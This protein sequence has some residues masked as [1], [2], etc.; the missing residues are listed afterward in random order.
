MKTALGLLGALAA[1]LAVSGALVAS[2]PL[3]ASLS[4]LAFHSLLVDESPPAALAPGTTTTYTMHFRNV[5]TT[6]WQRGGRTQVNLGV[7][8]DATSFA[9]AGLAA[10]WLS[11]TRIVST[12]E[13]LV[14]P[15][16]VGTFTF[17]VRA[18][19]TPGSYRI[20]VRLVA[21][22]ISWLDD[23][24]ASVVVTSDLGFHGQLVDQSAYPVLHPFGT[25]AP[26]SVRIRNVGARAWIKGAPGQQLNLGIVGDDKSLAGLGVEWPSADRVAIQTEPRVGPGGIATF[27]FRIRAGG[28]TGTYPIRLR[29][30]VDGVTWLEDFGLM[31][32]LSVVPAGTATTPAI[33]A[34]ALA[35]TASP[36]SFTA[37]ARANPNSLP[38]GTS[39]TVNATVT[40]STTNTGV[41]VG[42]GIYAPGAATLA[43][44]KWFHNENFA[45][46]EQHQYTVVWPV[47]AGSVAG[48]DTVSVSV[49]SAG[50]KQALA[51][52]F[53]LASFT[54]TTTTAL[55]P[56]TAAPTASA[57]S[58][59]S[60]PSPT[61]APTAAPSPTPAATP[62]PTPVPS[63]ASSAAVSPATAPAGSAVAVTDKVTSASAAT[64]LVDI[65]IWAAGAAAPAYQVWF[66]NLTFAAGQQQTFSASWDVPASAVPGTYTVKLG[67][68]APAWAAQY[69][70]NDAAATFA[71][72]AAPSPT[73][74]PSA[75]PSPP[76]SPS[77]TPSPTP[78]PTSLNDT[79][80]VYSG[81]WAV[82]TAAA[83]YLGD[84]HYSSTAGSSYTVSFRGT[85]V[86][87][88]AAVAP[89]HGIAAIS[90]DGSSPLNV[91][92]YSPTRVDQTLV[93]TSTVLASGTHTLTVTV[94]GR[95]NA[96]STDVILNADRADIVGGGLGP[97][98]TPAPT[99]TPAPTPTPTPAPTPTSAPTPTPTPASTP[100]P[101]PTAAPTATPA[102]SFSTSAS[103]TPTTVSPGG[104]VT[105][106]TSVTSA[107]AATVIVEVY[108][109]APDGTTLLNEQWFDNQTFAAG[110]RRTYTTSW[111]VPAGSAAG[112]Y[113]IDLGVF[114]LGWSTRYSWTDGAATFTVTAPATPAPTPSATPAP[115]P[116]AT[117]APTAAPGT[118]SALHVQGNKIVNALSQNVVLH[119]V[120]RSGFEQGCASYNTLFGE[121]PLDQASVD[122]IKSWRTNVVRVTLN[123][124][125]WLG[126]NGV[127]PAY[128]GSIYQAAVKS[129]VT[130]LNQSGLYA[131]VDLHWSAPGTT[132]ATGQQPMADMDHSPTYWTQVATAFKNN[133]GVIFD[134]YNE[135]WP[136]SNRDTVAAWTCWR[137]GGSCPG[138]PFQAAGM[139]TL[140]NAVRNTGATN[141]ILLGGVQYS[142]T[143]TQ[144]VQYKPADPQNNLAASWHGYEFNWC[145]T[146]TCY[147]SNLGTLAA[148]YPVVAEEVGVDNCDATWFNTLLNWLD[149]KGIGYLAWTW[150]I[151][152][153]CSAISLIS[154]YAGTPTQYGLIYKNHLA[155]LP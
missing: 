12:T 58:A 72:S 146:V 59:S 69:S 41:I 25:S 147:D 60:G 115:T 86:M 3:P 111:Q 62:T 17:S 122:A 149:S 42:V 9:E 48:V 76:A 87:L 53:A 7:V 150:N 51:G 102:P 132:L 141:L 137:D 105:V 56:P 124:D 100:T 64:A 50:W 91:D 75:T 112:V 21:D 16:T 22:G 73:P 10:R 99:A 45:A 20:P 71:V 148:Q 24:G 14:L 144:W 29:P 89:Y 138:V 118:I 120:N 114:A 85:Q 93:Y 1:A 108:V 113:N 92:L 2:T 153:G 97:T 88:F 121:G 129:W 139:Q 6:P 18:P 44:Q 47:P 104:T 46:G 135:P 81:S 106:T 95:K 154:D 123:E 33:D 136:D 134:L 155:A 35:L 28:A 49:Y 117:P 142:N 128:S 43:Y 110:Q 70:W 63:F 37:T 101:V 61:S 84:D 67:V 8:G 27:T 83:K 26:L 78:V 19:S 55:P 140:V 133:P 54:V 68:Y 116:S 34:A 119:G 38:T 127:N 5:G 80:F 125:C 32:I 145:V 15:G 98:P 40:S 36:R 52:P 23:N 130:L 82:S 66:D 30:V 131:I 94:T 74:S 11:P 151:W 57:P 143:F 152:G 126:I 79:L 103:L 77:T 39:V 90:L 109:Y 31:T 4:A 96:A 107:T 13:E 65:E